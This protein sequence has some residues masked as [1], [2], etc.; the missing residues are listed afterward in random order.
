MSLSATVSQIDPVHTPCAPSASAA[1]IW[2][3]RADPAGGEHRHVGPDRVDD[4][5]H[6]TIVEISPV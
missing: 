2:R 4:L 3:P 6:S 1:A 5:G